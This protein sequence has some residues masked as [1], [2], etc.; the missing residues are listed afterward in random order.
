[1]FRK[2]SSMKARALLVILT[3]GSLVSAFAFYSSRP[4]FLMVF[5]S[6]GLV[7]A[8]YASFMAKIFSRSLGSKAFVAIWATMLCLSIA[9][10]T[11]LRC[12][13]IDAADGVSGGIPLLVKKFSEWRTPAAL[14][15]LDSDK[16]AMSV[17][18]SIIN[19][20]RCR[21]EDLNKK[22]NATGWN[23]VLLDQNIA[24]R[25]GVEQGRNAIKEYRTV[26]DDLV[27]ESRNSLD[28]GKSVIGGMSEFTRQLTLDI[29]TRNQQDIIDAEIQV[30]DIQAPE[31]ESIQRMLDL[32]SEHL[33][34]LSAGQ[35]GSDL[36]SQ[37]E[38]KW[39]SS[40]S[41]LM[42]QQSAFQGQLMLAEYKLSGGY[43]GLD[44]ILERTRARSMRGG[45]PCDREKLAQVAQP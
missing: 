41:S 14:R 12:S 26:K 39:N 19:A 31:L 1:M 21:I 17:L 25:V 28:K 44:M 43:Q 27:A 23:R 36:N 40:G 45:F 24:S 11:S 20:D 18:A 10:E 9:A 15:S 13:D 4:L 3:L 37:Y 33:S 7:A 6:L 34:S 38:A 8:L 30:R 42:Q 5:A 22:A 16:H 29:Y 32:A 35:G 2:S